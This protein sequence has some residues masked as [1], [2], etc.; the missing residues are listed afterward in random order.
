MDEKIDIFNFVKRCNVQAYKSY[1]D[2]FDINI[3][4][5]S[6]IS[7]LHRAIA[8]QCPEIAF[9]LINRSINV[10]IQD[11]RGQSSLHYLGFYPN[12]ALAEA[13][14]QNGGDLELKDNYGNTPLWYVVFNARGNYAFVELLMQN[15]ANP[16]LLNNV[17]KTP[18][19]S[20]S[21]IKDQRLI[22]ILNNR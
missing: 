4:N 12:L 9:D 2:Q 22:E 5:V 21:P 16:N 18:H 11:D 17:G 15:K 7:L 3:T 1:I 19:D 6:G 20:A 8:H 10:N 13:I 14:I